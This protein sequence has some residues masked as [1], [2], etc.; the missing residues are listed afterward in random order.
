MMRTFRK[1]NDMCKTYIPPLKLKEEKIL[2][3]EFK[4]EFVGVYH[5]GTTHQGESFAIVFRA[6]LPGFIFRI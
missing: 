3:S 6:C 5:D 2:R 4:G 1:P